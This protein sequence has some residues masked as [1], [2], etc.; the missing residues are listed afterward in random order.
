MEKDKKPFVIMNLDKPRKFRMTLNAIIEMQEK[1]GIDIEKP[2]EFVQ[3]LL[4][5]PN[6]AEVFQFFRTIIYLG[7]KDEDPEITED[8]V[9]SILDIHNFSEAM[10]T[11]LGHMGIKLVVDPSKTKKLP[12]VV[13]PTTKPKKKSPGTGTLPLKKPAKSG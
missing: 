8:K 4:N 7:L 12:R 10:V 6:K 3:K 11:A 1:I 5:N 13:I 2:D 9:G